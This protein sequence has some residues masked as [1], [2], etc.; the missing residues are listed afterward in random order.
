MVTKAQHKIDLNVYAVKKIPWPSLSSLESH[1]VPSPRFP[2]SV[3]VSSTSTLGSTDP[4]SPSTSLCCS[5]VAQI[6]SLLSEPVKLENEEAR[7]VSMAFSWDLYQRVMLEISKLSR[8]QH[9]YMGRLYQGWIQ[10]S[11][12]HSTTA[13]SWDSNPNASSGYFPL[14]SQIASQSSASLDQSR[15][16]YVQMEYCPGASLRDEIDGGRMGPRESRKIWVFVR[17]VTMVWKILW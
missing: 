17:Q 2:Y 11:S 15:F 3:I 9:T 7:K 1:S 4:L 6:S 8:L 10:K 5:G 16:L 13:S 12:I 14:P